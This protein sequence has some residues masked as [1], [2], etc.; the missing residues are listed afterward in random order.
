MKTKIINHF[1]DHYQDFYGKYLKNGL[2]KLRGDEYQGLCPFHEDT[3]PSL[4]I[5][6]KTG[7][8]FC[9]GCREKGDIFN[10]YGKL[11]G[12]NT[13]FDFRIILSGIANNF[14]IPWQHRNRK[15]V[16]TY[17]YTDAEG[18]LLYQVCRFEP[19]VFRQ[20]R[21][22]DAN[23][24]IWDLKGVQRVLYRLPEVLKTDEIFLVEGEKDADNLQALGLK[25]TT[26]PG[27]AGKW[28]NSYTQ[29]L[30]GK[31]IFII[32]DNDEPGRK[33][34]QQVAAA[35]HLK[36]ASVRIVELPAE[37]NGKLIKDVSDFIDAVENRKKAGEQ[38]SIMSEAAPLWSPQAKKTAET[39][40]QGIVPEHQNEVKKDEKDKQADA[41]VRIGS[42]AELFVTKGGGTWARFETHGH[43]ECWGI[44]AGSGE[45][46][47]WLVSEFFRKNGT[48]PSPTAVQSAL[49]V[50]KSI[51]A[52]GGGQRNREIFTRV[53]GHEGHIYLDLA[54]ESWR[55][56]EI[57]SD[58]WRMVSNP[59]VYFRRT[60]GMLPLPEPKTGGDLWLLDNLVNLGGEESR[61]L[62]LSWLL[63]TLNPAGPYPILT[64]VSEQGSGKSTTAQ[65]LRMIIDPNQAPMRALPRN[66]ED[67]AV[68]AEHSWIPCFDNLG[69]M[70]NEFSDAF[71]R[72]ATGAGFAARQLY[73]NGE[74]FVFWAK[75]PVILNG[76]VEPASRPDLLER[77]LI[78]SLPTISP[79]E[80]LPEDDIMAAFKETWPEILGAVLDS[81]V[82][83]LGRL[84]EI[85]LDKY[86]RTADFARWAVAAAPVFYAEA[87]EIVEMLLQKQN[88]A[89]LSDLEHP[90][91]QAVLKL[92]DDEEGKVKM[93]LSELLSRL[94]E[95]APE[96]TTRA[97]TWPKIA[98]NLAS[99]LK[100]LSP[101]LRATG[102]VVSDAGRT[103]KGKVISI[104]RVTMG[105]DE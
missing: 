24:W 6:G 72:L 95:I 25:A 97:K 58:G 51:A 3:N 85:K 9:H 70:S 45:F 37:V 84:P 32:P 28:Q 81:V 92:V 91:V 23:G 40:S 105:D 36:T 76:I 67:L 27:G 46:R 39:E 20:R 88:E 79:G 38:L 29:A 4:S 68:A 73:T 30:V 8:F 69:H 101:V 54:D 50:I 35:L 12:L 14:G 7:E 41:M 43:L 49:E 86:P 94:N 63:F 83:L 100:R 66:L 96:E 52:F 61:R 13:R 53:A 71:C 44:Q 102:V 56:V 19:K 99:A 2:K 17:G 5:N 10:F 104:E 16:K 93:Q 62:I 33:H 98:R 55:A 78:V 75:R 57:S 59:P 21:P 60:K 47:Q 64:L 82:L 18:H 65:I 42:T 87:D 48:A 90:L 74:E 26:N 22:N 89:L 77:S 11:Y 15:L 1:D 103:N 31:H 34:A 80:R